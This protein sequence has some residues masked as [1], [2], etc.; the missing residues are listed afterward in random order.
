LPTS[1]FNN[2]KIRLHY[3]KERINIVQRHAL[4]L[5]RLFYKGLHQ[6][7]LVCKILA[8]KKGMQEVLKMVKSNEQVVP[9]A[10]YC[11]TGSTGYIGSW[12]VEALLER[13]C[14][15]HATVRDPG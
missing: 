2:L 6:V 11:V 4:Y 1:Y 3:I 8:V 15:V 12:L 13:G 7:G 9:G 5:A 14:T 10:K